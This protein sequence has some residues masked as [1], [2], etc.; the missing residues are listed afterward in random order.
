MNYLYG[1]RVVANPL[2]VDREYLILKWWEKVLQWNP[3]NGF[4]QTFIEVPK[5]EFWHD[6]INNILYG[7]PEM[8]EVLKKATLQP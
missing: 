8:I 3:C 4:V 1:M 6:R 5:K 7:H 2:L